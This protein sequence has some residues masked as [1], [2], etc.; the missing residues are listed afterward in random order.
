MSYI[1][2]ASLLTF[3]TPVMMAVRYAV[4]FPLVKRPRIGTEGCC[5]KHWSREML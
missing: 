3:G 1:A 2:L 5:K 4:L